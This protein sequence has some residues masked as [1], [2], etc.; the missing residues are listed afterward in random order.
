MSPHCV[1]PAAFQGKPSSLGHYP[2]S[3]LPRFPLTPQQLRM[4]QGTLSK[5]P[6]AGRAGFGGT[7]LRSAL[8]CCRNEALEQT[9]QWTKCVP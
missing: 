1:S 2:G 6:S 7:G 3:S 4:A 8:Q 9:K 5:P